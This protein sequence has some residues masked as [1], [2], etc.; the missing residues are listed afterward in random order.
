M[1]HAADGVAHR[2]ACRIGEGEAST[3]SDDGRREGRAPGGLISTL[4]AAILRT[5]ATRDLDAVLGEAVASA[6]ALTGARNGIIVTPTRRARPRTRC[7]RA[8]TRRRNARSSPGP[9]TPACSSIGALWPGPVRA[10]DFPG[11]G[12]RVRADLE[13]LVETSPVGVVVFDAKSGR[14]VS[15]NRERRSGP[16]DSSRKLR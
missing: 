3:Q 7:S 15:F 16:P 8:S 11:L 5:S 4:N 6:R 2:D 13:A 9:A 12:Q 10:V 1:Q 14:A